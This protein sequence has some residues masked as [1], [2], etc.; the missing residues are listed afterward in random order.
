VIV[1][2]ETRE[3]TCFLHKLLS[4]PHPHHIQ[5]KT[6]LRIRRDT[7]QTRLQPTQFVTKELCERESTNSTLFPGAITQ[8]YLSTSPFC[9]QRFV[10]PFLLREKVTR[11]LHHSN[12]ELSFSIFPF[13]DSFIFSLA[14][15]MADLSHRQWLSQYISFRKRASSL[16]NLFAHPMYD[17][18]FLVFLGPES[19]ARLRFG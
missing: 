5:S 11:V 1:N 8:S 4:H 15:H 18:C 14:C 16:H 9:G 12:H 3:F 19:C 10:A 13:Y 2:S 7:P 17:S 6:L